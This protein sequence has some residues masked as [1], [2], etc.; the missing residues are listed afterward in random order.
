MTT[1]TVTAIE[2]FN[3]HKPGEVFELTEREAKAAEA[4]GLV[5]MRVP[6]SNKMKVESENK[7]N[8]F[9]AG[10][11]GAPLSA[12]P[13][14]RVSRQTTAKPSGTGRPRGRPRKSSQ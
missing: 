10:G 2:P 12:S 6:V 5:K 13:A 7:Q 1:V 3:S 4:K 9:M 11:E 14:A 8:P